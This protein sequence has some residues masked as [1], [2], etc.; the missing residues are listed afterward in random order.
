V[1]IK[2]INK[3]G[4][5]RPPPA[6]KAKTG[7]VNLAVPDKLSLGETYVTAQ[8]RAD[9]L[10]GGKVAAQAAAVKQA[11]D[12]LAQKVAD[13]KGLED[14]ILVKDGEIVSA[15]QDY[16]TALQ[17]YA[18]GAVKAADGDVVVLQTLGVTPASITRSKITG[19]PEA[20][21][22]VRIAAGPTPGSLIVK[23][24]RPAGSGSFAVQYKLEPSKPED[25]WEAPE[26]L[27][28]RSTV[29]Q[30]GGLAPAQLVR[31]RVRALGDGWGP[32]SEEVMG[33]AQ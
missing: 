6:I 17:D 26:S 25:S 29:H 2:S 31:I 30:L 32:F 22:N 9:P 16:D 11:H 10:L 27:Q 14:T 3:K 18:L 13:R 1:T 28:S 19:P 21:E 33:R 24:S 23:H 5:L 20:P 8:D 4:R 12:T 7:V 15:I